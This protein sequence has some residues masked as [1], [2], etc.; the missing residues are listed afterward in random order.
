MYSIVIPAYN[1]EANLPATLRAAREAM[2]AAGAQPFEIIVADDDS[3]DATAAVAHENGARVIRSG[4]RN[5]GASRNAGA[6]EARGEVLIFIDADTLITP[7]T[8]RGAI[9]ALDSGAI[10]GGA[11]IAWS[12]PVNNHAANGCLRL[13]NWYSKVRRLPAGSFF[14][15]LKTDF[16]AVGGFDERFYA[17][18][19]LHLGKALKKRGRLEIV[20]APVLTSPR[21]IDQFTPLEFLGTLFR[22]AR[23][24]GRALKSRDALA[25]WYERR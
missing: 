9:A 15:M 18:E 17:S 1:E 12:E 5:I 16:D 20:S 25:Y 7:G 24:G 4:K 6:R 23:T 2:E 10:G 22:I 21:K 11:A 13:W 19:E 3:T 8:V 14:F